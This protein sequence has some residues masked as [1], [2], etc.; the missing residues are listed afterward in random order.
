MQENSPLSKNYR[1]EL[2]FWLWWAFFLNQA[3][4]AIFGVVLSGIKDELDLTDPQI[5]LIGSILF[6]TLAILVPF[7]GYAGDIFSRR[8]IITWCLGFWSFATMLTG[9]SRSVVTL[10]IF[11]SI[12]TGGGEAFYAPA[13]NAMISQFHRKTRSLALSIHQTSLYAGVI[14]SGFLGGWVADLWGWRAAFY[15]FGGF[16]VVLAIILVFRLKDAPREAVSSTTTEELQNVSQAA[17]P[18]LAQA[19]LVLLRTPTALCVT[20]AFTTI[21]FVNNGYVTWAPTFLEEKFNMSRASAGG[22]SMLYHHVFALIGVLIGGP[23]T[24]VIVQKFK[25]FRL[26]L[27]SI[28]LLLGAPFIVLMGMGNTE[29]AIYIGMGGFGLFRGL[30]ESN[31]YASLYDVIEP[32]LRSSASGIMIFFAFMTGAFSPWM[33]GILKPRLGLAQGMTSLAV[34]YVIGAVAILIAL[35]FFFKRDYI[36]E[37]EVN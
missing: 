37:T 19:I 7:A 31:T 14:L 21:V 12:A 9:L 22:F 27:Q 24:D 17:A 5:G 2:L 29:L 8:K 10:T 13:A 3:D 28:C 1:W 20:L 6:W 25:N 16:G 32:R 35:L 4:R 26:I 15:I 18:S 11:R 30:F 33:L 34:P 23:L 36:Q